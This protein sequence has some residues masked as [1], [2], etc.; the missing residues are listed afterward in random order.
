[1]KTITQE[2]VLANGGNAWE[3]ESGSIKRIYINQDTFV[4]LFKKHFDE[5]GNQFK[6][7][8]HHAK[9][10][11]IWFDCNDNTLHSL[12]GSIRSPLNGTGYT[13]KGK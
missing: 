8:M 6:D 2:Q 13:C 1:M 9:N 3:N 4:K 5:Y 7:V 11:K 10:S 12:N